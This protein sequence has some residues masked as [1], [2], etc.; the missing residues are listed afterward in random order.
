MQSYIVAGIDV[1]LPYVGVCQVKE[2][3]VMYRQQP[4]HA[5]GVRV[6]GVARV[7]GICCRQAV[8]GRVR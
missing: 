1:E 5:Q 8:L 4:N 3:G 7:G 2:D 6:G